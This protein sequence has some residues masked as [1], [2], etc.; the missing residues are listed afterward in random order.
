MTEKF[1]MVEYDSGSYSYLY[2]TFK[3]AEENAANWI[4]DNMEKPKE[5]PKELTIFEV[6]PVATTTIKQ[7]SETKML[8][9]DELL[10][11]HMIGE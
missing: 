1:Y 3:E 9:D 10:N 7:V 4:K 11:S 6:I 5:K 2:D 8:G